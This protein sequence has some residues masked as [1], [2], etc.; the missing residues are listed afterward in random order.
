MAGRRTVV[1]LSLLIALVSSAVAAQ[2][3]S[4]VLG[5]TAFE[6]VEVELK[7]GDHNDPHC[8]EYSG[9]GDYAHKPIEENKKLGVIV[10]NQKTGDS[11][12]AAVSANFTGKAGKVDVKISC[13]V[14]E[15]KAIATNVPSGID[16]VLANEGTYLMDFSGCTVS[17]PAKCKVEEPIEADGPFTTRVGLGPEK[18]TMSVEF[19]P[20][21]VGGK[22]LPFIEITF[23]GAECSLKGITANVDGTALA[24]GAAGDDENTKSS[25]ATLKFTEAMTKETLKTA[26]GAAEF[27]STVT[28]SSAE[29]GKPL[30]LTTTK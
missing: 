13:T 18:N 9:L 14:V 23:E 4:A 3:A 27:S 6:C 28:L 25:G 26:V 7:L 5:T 21:V 12:K 2:S 8:S 17:E 10:N 22:T 15:G 24:T 29:T 16:K 19:K 11:T 1:G 20:L 30:T